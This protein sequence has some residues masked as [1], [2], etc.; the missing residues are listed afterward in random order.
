METALPLDRRDLNR[1]NTHLLIA[2]HAFQHA[3]MDVFKDHLNI[4]EAEKNRSI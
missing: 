2:N 4:S 3:E 1:I